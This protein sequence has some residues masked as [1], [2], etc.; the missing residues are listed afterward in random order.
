MPGYIPSGGK[1]G[2]E[3]QAGRQAAAPASRLATRAI[4]INT[5]SRLRDEPATCVGL[6]VDRPQ[7]TKNWAVSGESATWD[8]ACAQVVQGINVETHSDVCVPRDWD[9]VRWQA[10]GRRRSRDGGSADVQ[11]DAMRVGKQEFDVPAG[12]LEPRE[13]Q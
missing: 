11:Q 10:V 4:T 12:G 8:L 9:G 3:W 6:C 13:R 5:G 1:W 7:P 2:G